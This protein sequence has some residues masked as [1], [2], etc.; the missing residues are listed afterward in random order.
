MTQKQFNDKYREFVPQGRGGLEF[1][2]EDVTAYMDLIM[3]DMIKI[4]G[5]ELHQIKLKFGR[6]RFY[7]ETGW[8]N[9]ELEGAIMLKVEERIDKLVRGYDKWNSVAKVQANSPYNDG[10]TREYYEKE[11]KRY[12]AGA[13]DWPAQKS[14]ESVD[15]DFMY[16]WIRN[17]SGKAVKKQDLLEENWMELE[18][19]DEYIKL[20][21]SGMFYEFYPQ[22]T[23]DWQ[24][25][26]YAFCH[27]RKYGNR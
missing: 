25:D 19:Y 15:A 12:N 16:N 4:P 17:K 7:F 21:E 10:W 22:F 13:R 3:Q 6:A 23:G 5:F 1:D 18:Y 27:E 2:L 24:K 8:A 26:K 11:L 14:E 9:K 20:K